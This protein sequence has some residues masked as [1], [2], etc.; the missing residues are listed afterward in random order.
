MNNDIIKPFIFPYNEILK[1]KLNNGSLLNIIDCDFDTSIF[2]LIVNCGSYNEVITENKITNGLAHLIEHIIFTNN[3]LVD[4]LTNNTCNYNAA[5]S[6]NKTT[7][8][9]ECLNKDLL[10][11][12]DLTFDIFLNID[13]QFTRKIIK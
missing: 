6:D 1:T 5:T 11:Y 8:Y 4:S 7:F 3:N 12:I 9:F 2:C 10:N 13:N